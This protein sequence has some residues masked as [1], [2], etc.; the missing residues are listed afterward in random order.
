MMV[1]LFVVNVKNCFTCCIYVCMYVCMYVC[2]CYVRCYDY[3]LLYKYILFF[4]TLGWFFST[5]FPVSSLA[6]YD[7]FVLAFTPIVF[8]STGD[9]YCVHNHVTVFR[10]AMRSHMLTCAIIR[11]QFMLSCY[12]CSHI[13]AYSC[14]SYVSPLWCSD[15]GYSNLIFSPCLLT[16]YC[17]FHCLPLF[18]FLDIVLHFLSTSC[19][20]NDCFYIY[21]HILM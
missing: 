1:Y 11:V 17:L 20:I 5:V 15:K 12:V 9:L 10:C 16:F 21:T 3:S 6:L 18:Y 7:I 13:F 14:S 19:C 8:T 4:C 2:T